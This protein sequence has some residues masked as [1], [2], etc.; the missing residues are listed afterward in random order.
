MMNEIKNK[1]AL[2]NAGGWRVE[3][4]VPINAGLLLNTEVSG[5]E[6]HV[7]INGGRWGY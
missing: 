2:I 1:M 3:T 6:V 7:L 4:S 5:F